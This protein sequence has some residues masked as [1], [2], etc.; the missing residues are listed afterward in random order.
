HFPLSNTHFE[1]WGAAMLKGKNYADEDKPLN[2]DLFNGV[3]NKS[4]AARSP[5]LQ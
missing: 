2:G 5:I 3:N 4:L 1:S